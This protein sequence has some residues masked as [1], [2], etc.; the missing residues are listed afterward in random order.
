MKKRIV[1]KEK[2]PSRMSVLPGINATDW[3]L[4]GWTAKIRA[5]KKDERDSIFSFLKNLYK[6]IQAIAW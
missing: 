2:I 3:T 4:I 5:K 1:P 6:R